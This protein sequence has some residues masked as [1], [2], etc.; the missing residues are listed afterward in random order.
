MSIDTAKVNFAS[1]LTNLNRKFEIT[2]SKWTDNQLY[3]IKFRTR[4]AVEQ[5]EY[6]L[7]CDQWVQ[8]FS[9]VTNTVWVHKISNT[10]P[11]V[12]FRKQYQCWAYPTKDVDKKL[13]FDPR[14]CR[15]T[16][17]IKILESLL[18]KKRPSRFR[19]LGFNT[20]VKLSFQHLHPID[21]T[22]DFSYFVHHCDPIFEAP[23]LPVQPAERLQQLMAKVFENAA[24]TSQKA[25]DR[26][27]EA[28][29]KHCPET[30][31]CKNPQQV[32]LAAA[33]EPTSQGIFYVQQVVFDSATQTLKEV[34]LGSNNI[35]HQHQI[36]EVQVPGDGHV[37][38]GP[39]ASQISF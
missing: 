11:K 25:A 31:T 28:L 33:N 36:I 18:N 32:V 3:E 30:A 24:V 35:A 20:L 12:K 22:K 10:G 7:Y 21:P 15:A 37:S 5:E 13:L 14:K 29:R 17:D 19:K 27:K 26:A 38:L 16:V 39:N 34:A 4:L 2:D 8:E 23:K 6:N 9:S 1:I